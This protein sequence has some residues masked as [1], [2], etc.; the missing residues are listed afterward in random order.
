[1]TDNSTGLDRTRG[2]LVIAA[3][4]GTLFFNWM[5]ATGRVNGVT[6][7]YISDLYPTPVTPAGYAFTIW[8]LIYLG[9]VA[10]SIYQMLP[11][12]AESARKI[13]SFYILAC[14]LNC[15][16]IYMWHSNQIAICLVLIV[17]L[18]VC[19]FLINI[20]LKT[21]KGMA[22]YWLIKA[23]FGLYFGWI[24]AAS[25]VNLAVL[26]VALPAGLSESAFNWTGVG[27]ILFAG[28]LGVLISLRLK[29]YL[30]PLAIAWAATAIGV[31]QSTNTP[32]VFA[33]AFATIACLIATLSFVIYLPSTTTPQREDGV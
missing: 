14:A 29:N 27:L 10:Y 31:K 1:M 25:L 15:G 22:E 9:S 7:E 19:L 17:L 13:R 16:W 12:A 32:I 30:Y 28:F 6:P 20:R 4:I 3:T 21:T 26:L 23:P 5:A 8:S 24:T 11:S 2:F 33:A 18:W